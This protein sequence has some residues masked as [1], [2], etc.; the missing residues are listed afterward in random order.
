M[1]WSLDHP[2]KNVKA[3]FCFQFQSTFRPRLSILQQTI[4]YLVSCPKS[5]QIAVLLIM[6]AIFCEKLQWQKSGIRNLVKSFLK[7]NITHLYFNELAL[8]SRNGYFFCQISFEVA[9]GW[10][11]FFI[12][13]LNTL[14]HTSTL[15]FIRAEETFPICEGETHLSPVCADCTPPSRNCVR[16]GPGSLTPQSLEIWWF[17]S[18]YYVNY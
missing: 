7:Q 15:G 14:W 16:G 4:C 3:G 1:F 10:K 18:F 8:Q 6:S 2:K 11:C 13:Q 9:Y 12:T 17:Q 5:W